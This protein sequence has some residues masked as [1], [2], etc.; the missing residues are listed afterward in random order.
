ME[1]RKIG[2]L[3][4]GAMGGGIAHLAAMR[5]YEVV[6]SDVEQSILDRAIK[7][8]VD[9]MDKRVQKQ[10]MTVEEKDAVLAKLRTTTKLEEFSDVDVAIEA[11]IEVPEIKKEVFGK[12]DS[13]CRKD[14]ILASNTSSISITSIASATSRP[15]KVVGMHFFNPPQVMQLV[16]VVRGYYSSDDTVAATM[17][18]ARELGKTPIEI[19]KDYPG[20]VVNRLMLAQYVE[21]MKL[22]EEGVATP[23]DIDIGVKLGL[24]HPMGVFELQDFGG[25]DIGYFV[26]NYLCEES[27]ESR[28]NPPNSLKLLIRANRLGRKTGSGWFTYNR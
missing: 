22:V 13:I 20:F 8:M 18:L 27:K 17:E 19:K 23:E 26:L 14:V 7:R 3:G 5:G 12:L 1:V 25:L 10:K 28:W 6:L 24:N 9:L 15:D 11:V 2:V 16:E 21:A 4:A